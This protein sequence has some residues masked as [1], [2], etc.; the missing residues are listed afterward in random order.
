M[1]SGREDALVWGLACTYELTMY[2]AADG[3]RTSNGLHIGLLH[4]DLPGLQTAVR[5]TDSNRRTRAEATMLAGEKLVGRTHFVTETLY[6]DLRQLFALTQLFD[7]SVDFMFHLDMCGCARG[8]RWKMVGRGSLQLLVTPSVT[9]STRLTSESESASHG[10]TSGRVH[11]RR[12]A[13]HSSTIAE[14][15]SSSKNHI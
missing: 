4:Q 5:D 1:L 2:I 9:R 8:V 6:V 12:G 11:Y 13:S 14:M 3:H 15:I 10:R 7:P